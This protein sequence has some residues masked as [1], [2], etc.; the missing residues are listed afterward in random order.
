MLQP[1]SARGDADFDKLYVQPVYVPSSL[2]YV[3]LFSEPLQDCKANL[4]CTLNPETDFDTKPECTKRTTSV[5]VQLPCLQCRKT[6]VRA[7]FRE[8]L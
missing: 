6:C 1:T 8:T 3:Q 7:R 2:P 5:N 4:S